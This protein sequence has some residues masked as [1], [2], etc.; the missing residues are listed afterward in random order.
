MTD[1]QGSESE[2]AIRAEVDRLRLELKALELRMMDRN[3]H[4]ARLWVVTIALAS[5]ALSV[6]VFGPL[7]AKP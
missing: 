7:L 2:R 4:L 1:F 5:L 6:A 3:L